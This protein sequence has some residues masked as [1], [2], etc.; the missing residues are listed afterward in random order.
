M[1]PNVVIQNYLFFFT[2]HL[3]KFTCYKN[4][5]NTELS[6]KFQNVLQWNSKKHFELNIIWKQKD[7]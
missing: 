3:F 6:S 2:L 4:Y 1:V 7:M 5:F